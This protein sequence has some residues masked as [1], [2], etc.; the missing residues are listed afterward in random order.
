MEAP[1]RGKI[2]SGSK[3]DWIKAV[4]RTNRAPVASRY[5]LGIVVGSDAMTNG[6]EGWRISG[7]HSNEFRT[8]P[9]QLVF[10]YRDTLLYS[11]TGAKDKDNNDVIAMHKRPDWVLPL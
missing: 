5:S 7:G 2:V 8:S 1:L 10:S 11:V 3:A 4:I 9:L 6:F